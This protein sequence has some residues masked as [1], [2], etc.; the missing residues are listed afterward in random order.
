MQ[1]ATKVIWRRRNV[2]LNTPFSAPEALQL[3]A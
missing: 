1:D 2:F 3:T